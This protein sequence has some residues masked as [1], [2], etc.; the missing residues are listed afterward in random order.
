MPSTTSLLA[1]PL[2][3]I[4]AGVRQI[5]QAHASQQALRRDLDTYTTDSD[6]NDLGATL[7][8]YDDDDTRDI[9]A[10]LAAQRYR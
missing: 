8:R 9:R 2:E 10:I 5:R 3:A 1:P 6:L 4:R 7:D